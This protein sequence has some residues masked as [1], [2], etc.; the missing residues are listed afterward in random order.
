M[1][2]TQFYFATSSYTPKEFL[3]DSATNPTM[4]C[5]NFCQDNFQYLVCTFYLSIRFRMAR[6]CHYVFNLVFLHKAPYHVGCELC[7]STRN[8]F[9][10][11]T[12][13]GKNIFK[14]EICNHLFYCFR[15]CF[16]FHLL[17]HIIS[18]DQYVNLLVRRWVARPKEIDGP[19]LK[20][21]KDYL[22]L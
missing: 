7:S 17:S 14:K 6:S 1:V 8:N 2:K 13:S 18:A 9:S 10:W 11:G 19:L 5:Y 4:T 22:E 20:R 12:I 21:L 3:E 15:N 16:G